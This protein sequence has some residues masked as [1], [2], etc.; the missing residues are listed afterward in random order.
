MRIGILTLPFNNNYGGYLQ[1]YA[2]M[3]VLKRMGY[4]PTMIMRRHNKKKNSFFFYLK[5]AVKGI[6]KSILKLRQYPLIYEEERVF[7]NQGK[8][9]LSFVNKNVFPQ[10]PYI[11]TTEKL[12]DYCNGR[13]DAF[14]VGSDQVWRPDYVNGVLYNLFL[15]FT[16]GWNVKRIAYAASFGTD[17]PVY[18]NEQSKICGEL[19]KNFDAISLR[20]SSGINVFKKLGW[21]YG[22]IETVLDPTM[23]LYK[24]DYLSLLPKGKTKFRNSILSYVLDANNVIGDI[25]EKISKY[26][27]KQLYTF[28]IRQR[29]KPS[30]EDWLLAFR[31]CDFV[32]TDS[33]HGTVFSIIFNKP[34]LVIVNKERGA[35]RFYNLLRTYKL[36]N[37]IVN[38]SQDNIDDILKKD[39]DWKIVNDIINKNRMKSLDFLKKNLT[40]PKV[41]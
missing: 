41:N 12:K 33:F 17:Y 36:E 14:I 15:D 26:T 8:M 21:S 29:I 19:T 20:E 10:S 7:K 32:I 25:C 13:F 28:D 24:T 22:N 1:A 9:M 37:R 38:T 2:L 31:D 34:F 6:I 16:K 18:N 35:D 39:I 5:Y 40:P 23:I 30:I 27:G 3:T 4:E 11:Y